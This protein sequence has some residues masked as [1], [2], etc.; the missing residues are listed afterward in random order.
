[1]LGSASLY[2]RQLAAKPG[3]WRQI[4]YLTSPAATEGHSRTTGPR[5]LQIEL[6]A[7]VLSPAA[8]QPPIAD[9]AAVTAQPIREA[10]L[11]TPDCFCSPVSQA[12][13]AQP[14]QP[15][16]SSDVRPTATPALPLRRSPWW[17]LSR[18]LAHYLPWVP[19]T[20]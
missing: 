18:A 4:N 17:P 15:A 9:A 10:Y 16:T 13:S 7:P 20:P 2:S 19:Q 8:A 1:M 14:F 11:I 3:N 5:P 6:Q 12:A